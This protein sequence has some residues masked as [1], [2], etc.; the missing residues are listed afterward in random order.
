MLNVPF[1]ALDLEKIKFFMTDRGLARYLFRDFESM[2]TAFEN[3]R[4][5]VRDSMERYKAET[6]SAKGTEFAS[7]FT[8]T[9]KS[10]ESKIADVEKTIDSADPADRRRSRTNQSPAANE[11]YGRRKLRSARQ[12]GRNNLRMI[13]LPAA[14]SGHPGRPV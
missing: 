6:E 2:K 4:Q 11:T 9:E 10:V 12:P 3:L 7:M 5:S 8:W 14:P 13:V 1:V